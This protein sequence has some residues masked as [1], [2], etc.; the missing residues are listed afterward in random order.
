MKSYETLP[1]GYL[2]AVQ[3]DLLHDRRQ[4]T[5]VTTLNLV[6]TV[7][8]V[9]AAVLRGHP[10]SFRITD[11]GGYLLK[12]AA[13]VLGILLYLALHELVHGLVTTLNGAKAF[14]GFRVA[15][16]YAGSR[17]YF[18]RSAYIAVALAP[19]IVWGLVLALVLPLIP[20]GWFWV[21]YLIQVMNLGGAAGDYYVTYRILK[22]P[23]DTL[24][25]DTGIEMTFFTK[26]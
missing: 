17:A 25:Q 15:Y 13:C 11:Y 21:V 7:V 26:E 2:P 14:Y 6:I 22:M 5:I 9:L 4:M 23:P 24:V 20:A 16:A 3:L 19:V 12:L 1:A 8:M 10:I 18:S